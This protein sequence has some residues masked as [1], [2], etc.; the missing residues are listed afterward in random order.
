MAFR[1]PYIST[2]QTDI[3]Q[4]LKLLLHLGQ[5]LMKR[6]N[7]AVEALSINRMCVSGWHNN[8]PHC[9][10]FLYLLY[11]P[12]VLCSS[13]LCCNVT[14][15]KA[16]FCIMLKKNIQKSK[17]FFYCVK[18]YVCKRMNAPVCQVFIQFIST[19]LQ[20]GHSYHWSWYDAGQCWLSSAGVSENSHT[21][22]QRLQF[23][24]LEWGPFCWFDQFPSKFSLPKKRQASTVNERPSRQN[25][26]TASP[27]I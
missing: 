4:L 25:S 6:M 7:E 21:W 14:K 10:F 12:V 16:I 18:L 19:A 23:Q 1:E 8:Y 20:P 15:V 24:L 22:K 11:S 5:F 3:S 2:Q 27:Y 13:S 17:N 9:H 26:S